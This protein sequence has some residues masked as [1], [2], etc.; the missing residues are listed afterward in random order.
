MDSRIPRVTRAIRTSIEMDAKGFM[1]TLNTLTRILTVFKSIFKTTDERTMNFRIEKADTKEDFPFMTMQMVM[2]MM[3]EVCDI[4]KMLRE[5]QESISRAYNSMIRLI[6]EPEALHNQHCGLYPID[7]EYVYKDQCT[8]EKMLMNMYESALVEGTIIWNEKH[9]IDTARAM[10]VGGIKQLHEKI[11]SKVTLAEWEDSCGYPTPKDCLIEIFRKLLI[12]NQ[13]VTELH[14]EE[15]CAEISQDYSMLFDQLTVSDYKR[16]A[17][18]IHMAQN[19]NE[20]KLRAL[21]YITKSLVSRKRIT[22]AK[23]FNMYLSVKRL[24]NMYYQNLM[25]NTVENDD[26]HNKFKHQ[27]VINYS[28][29]SEV[30]GEDEY[31]VD[32]EEKEEVKEKEE[33]G[34]EGKEEGKILGSCCCEPYDCDCCKQYE[35][36]V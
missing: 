32:N 21:W 9:V 15:T 16:I 13:S 18:A 22:F 20:D 4:H 26:A 33:E 12:S 17:D 6:G 1:E 11:C 2:K 19:V 34:N 5:T 23:Q 29:L 10:Q 31:V 7:Q 30:E 3:F 36:K 27:K 8:G 35:L 25:D 14:I 24:H 28:E